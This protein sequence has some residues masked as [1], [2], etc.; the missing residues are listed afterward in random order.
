M[1]LEETLSTKQVL[2]ELFP[3]STKQLLI[4]IHLQ[5]KERVLRSGGPIFIVG[6]ASVSEKGTFQISKG[7]FSSPFSFSSSNPGFN[8][9]NHSSDKDV[10]MVLDF[11][12][13]RRG[14]SKKVPILVECL[15]RNRIWNVTGRYLLCG[16]SVSAHLNVGYID[17]EVHWTQ[18]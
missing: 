8:S 13:K 5:I 2:F 4:L 7:W 6:C 10:S 12:F 18:K 1:I 14:D 11:L 9:L 16:E 3:L 17:F 15:S